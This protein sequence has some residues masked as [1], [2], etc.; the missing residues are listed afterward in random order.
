MS[1]EAGSR[2]V[3]RAQVGWSR[4]LHGIPGCLAPLWLTR[5]LPLLLLV[6]LGPLSLKS[7]R[8]WEVAFR[9]LDSVE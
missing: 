3:A 9:L 1:L 7:A 2:Q 5:E 4:T 6:G 8:F